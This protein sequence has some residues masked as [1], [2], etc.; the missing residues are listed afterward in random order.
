MSDRSPQLL[1]HPFKC[2]LL[3]YK[4]ASLIIPAPYKTKHTQTREIILIKTH[5]SITYFSVNNYWHLE[6]KSASILKD[7]CCRFFLISGKFVPV[8]AQPYLRRQYHLYST[9]LEH[10][11]PKNNISHFC[12]GVYSTNLDVSDLILWTTKPIKNTVDIH[13][14][15]SLI[16]S[17][18]QIWF[19]VI[20]KII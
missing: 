3:G 17:I 1:T 16:Y 8:Y 4:I 7:R 2:Y 5:L 13:I 9:Q 12:L 15:K 10:Q 6:D 20:W 11:I 19:Q 14:I 18:P